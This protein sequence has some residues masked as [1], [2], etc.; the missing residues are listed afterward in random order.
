MTTDWVA[1]HE[2]YEDPRSFLAARLGVIRGFI[3]DFLDSRPGQDSRVVSFCAG[4]GLDLLGVL[5]SHPAKRQVTARL[6]ELDPVL[7]DEARRAARDAGLTNIEVVVAD[8]GIT[9][10][11]V[12]AVPADLVMVCGVFGNISDSDVETTVRA[13]PTLCVQG[14]TIIWTRHRRTPDLTPTIRDWFSAAGFAERAFT[15]PGVG[16][17]AVGVHQ[18]DGPGG[19]LSVGQQLFT[20]AR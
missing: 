17:F 10:A 15:S 4:K 16:S 11:Y 19:P 3:L 12:G 18:L 8:A 20:F 5:P 9:D 13:M 1:W 2:R 7:A 14:G 6:V